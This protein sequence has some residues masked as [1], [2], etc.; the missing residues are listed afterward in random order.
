MNWLLAILGVIAVI[1]FV[2]SGMQYLLSAG[3][4]DW[5]EMAKRNMKYSIVGIVVALSGLIIIRAIDSL[6]QGFSFFSFF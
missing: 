1:A 6:L 3:D 2:I 5:I 4:E